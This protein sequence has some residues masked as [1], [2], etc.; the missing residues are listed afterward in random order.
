MMTGA[1]PARIRMSWNNFVGPEATA[2]DNTVTLALAALGAAAAPSVTCTDR[3]LTTGQRLI[4]RLLATDLWGGAWVNNT[5]ACARWY[6]RPGQTEADHM[7]FAAMHIH[8]AVVAWMDRED[9]PHRVH[10]AMWAGA[11]YGYLMAATYLIRRRP[12]QRRLLGTT[13]TVGG[14]VLD[15]AL[16]RSHVA[17]WFAPVYYVKLLLG[18]ASATLSL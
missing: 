15:Q 5:R 13:M 1:L 12:H 17:P 11:H 16:G 6:E 18:H 14:V 2:L 9:R 4:L 3:P 10:P 8:P 7:A